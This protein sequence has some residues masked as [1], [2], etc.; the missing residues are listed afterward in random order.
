LLNLFKEAN[1]TI[2]AS[3]DE[4]EGEN[5]DPS[6]PVFDGLSCVVKLQNLIKLLINIL[7]MSG[8]SNI[9]IL[10]GS[11]QIINK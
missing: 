7:S 10:T 3:V 1:E 4:N 8:F 6:A 5:V 11:N 2:I 9:D